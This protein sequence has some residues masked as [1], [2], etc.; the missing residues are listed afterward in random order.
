MMYGVIVYITIGFV[1]LFFT[2]ETLKDLGINNVS[3]NRFWSICKTVLLFL[4][5]AIMIVTLYLPIGIGILIYSIYFSIRA[6]SQKSPRIE[7]DGNLYLLNSSGAGTVCCKDCDFKEEAFGF[8]HGFGSPRWCKVTLQCQECG[9][10]ENLEG[11][12]RVPRKGKCQCGGKL[13]R[14]VPVFCPTCKSKNMSY[15]LRY[16]T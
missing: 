10:F 16:M 14:E 1:I 8:V 12:D 9:Q 11:Y 4:G 15:H 6:Y 2:R 3:E 5:K 13:S 7:Y